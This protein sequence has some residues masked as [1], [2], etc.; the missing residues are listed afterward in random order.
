MESSR[1]FIVWDLRRS[2]SL[3]LLFLSVLPQSLGASQRQAVT[4][5]QLLVRF[6]GAEGTW[7][8]AWASADRLD[9][10]RWDTPRPVAQPDGV[11]SGSPLQR[12]A[13]VRFVAH[14]ESVLDQCGDDRQI[15]RASLSFSTGTSPPVPPQ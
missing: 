7:P 15:T 3:T 1:G 2:I 6:A 9:A 10:M 11:C 5:A 8:F 13:R 14:G 4:V 12:S